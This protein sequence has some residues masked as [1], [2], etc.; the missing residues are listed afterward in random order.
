MIFVQDLEYI[1][2]A[3]PKDL[4]YVVSNLVEAVEELQAIVEE[5]QAK[6]DKGGK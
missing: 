1:P 6:L 4:G 2:E 3:Y 5:L